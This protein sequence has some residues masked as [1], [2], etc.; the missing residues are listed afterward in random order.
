MR[1]ISTL[2]IFT[3]CF[4]RTYHSVAQT[5]TTYDVNGV[6]VR[7]FKNDQKDPDLLF[8]GDS[9]SF[10]YFTM[11]PYSVA[12][13]HYESEN[14][15]RLDS[16]LY[17]KS[18]NREYYHYVD[19]KRKLKYT[20]HRNRD[21][22]VS[23]TET[24]NDSIAVINIVR[25]K[26][27]DTVVQSDTVVL[28]YPDSGSVDYI[29]NNITLEALGEKVYS[30][31]T[32]Y[33]NTMRIFM[34]RYADDPADD[35]VVLYT[36]P[37]ITQK[38]LLVTRKTGEYLYCSLFESK[39]DRIKK[40]TYEST[41]KKIVNK[42]INKILKKIT[43]SK[44]LPINDF[45]EGTVVEYVINGKYY[46]LTYL[47]DINNFFMCGDPDYQIEE[48]MLNNIKQLVIYLDKCFK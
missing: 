41:Q 40:Y 48:E 24:R 4:F 15:L 12:F 44:S 35:F 13:C 45:M 20:Y 23:C 47:F 43:S 5:D 19:G 27:N 32:S 9:S 18:G 25:F 34:M 31:D 33:N 36:I 28:Y 22:N 6:T 42:K 10:S 37:D 21:I 26:D 14:R 8:L 1:H 30:S 16:V 29:D 46:Y 17:E 7:V 3:C 2:L 38:S 39:E 11:Y